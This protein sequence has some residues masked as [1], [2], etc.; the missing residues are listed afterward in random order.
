MHVIT[1]AEP[2]A[3]LRLRASTI[4]TRTK[5]RLDPLTRVSERAA[6]CDYHKVFEALRGHGAH[7]TESEVSDGR[8]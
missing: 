6:Q 7:E 8:P 3:R 4:H 1:T 2:A 5:Q